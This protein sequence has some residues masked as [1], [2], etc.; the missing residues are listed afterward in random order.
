MAINKII[1]GFAKPLGGVMFF[2]GLV[3]IYGT[4]NPEAPFNQGR[5]SKHIIMGPGL[6]YLGL[7]LLNFN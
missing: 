7:K 2:L 6:I 1:G 4:I 3:F 5:I